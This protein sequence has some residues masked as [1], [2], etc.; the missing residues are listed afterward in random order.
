MI[1]GPLELRSHAHSENNAEPKIEYEQFYIKYRA[2]IQDS[3][4]K[5]MC[6]YVAFHKDYGDQVFQLNCHT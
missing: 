4:Y 5:L 1:A 2:L 6:K 3:H